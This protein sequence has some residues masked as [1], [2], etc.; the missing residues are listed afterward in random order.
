MRQ[1]L[2][3]YVSECADLVKKIS[4]SGKEEE[5]ITVVAP[6][7]EGGADVHG[8]EW[9]LGTYTQRFNR[10]HKQNAH[11]F[12]GATRRSLPKNAQ[13]A[14]CGRLA[15]T[16][17]LIRCGA[18]RIG[19]EEKLEAYRSSSYVGYRQPKERPPWLRIERPFGEH[20][21]HSSEPPGV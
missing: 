13:P 10:G 17:I 12:R 8:V 7:V 4:P 21:G 6:G 20:S 14:S 1:P 19:A 11:L 18:G 2:H 15:I 3:E 9:F 16:C 5:D